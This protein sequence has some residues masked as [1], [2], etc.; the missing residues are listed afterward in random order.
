MDVR[1]DGKVALVTGGS[2]GI[3]KAIARQFAESGAKV[4]IAAR[5]LDGLQSAAAEITGDV[6]GDVEVFAANAGSPDD[7]HACVAATIERFGSLDI[8]VNNAATNPFYDPTLEVDLP[9]YD[10]TMEVNLRGTVV[11]TQ[12]AWRQSFSLAPGK[13]VINI[14]SVGG[15][16]FER[17]LGVYNLTKAAMM[18]L[19][20]QLA[21]EMAP[22]CRVVCIA[23]GLVRTGFSQVLI[24]RAPTLGE[25]LPAR[26]IGEPSD[27]GAFATFLASDL[28]GWITGHTYVID[29]GAEA[30]GDIE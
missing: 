25:R 11:W 26:R 9:R 13:V 4:M 30:T 28:A 7:A 22:N 10:K 14:S 12:E 1:L 16:H 18:Q 23:P 15:L 27:I 8:L 29:G 5:K 19:T 17:G 20:N 2:R 24:D 6:G 21:N 3:G